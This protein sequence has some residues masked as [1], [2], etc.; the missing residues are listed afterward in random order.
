MKSFTNRGWASQAFEPA[1]S[2]YR[3]GS[4]CSTF[5]VS[6][7]SAVSRARLDVSAAIVSVMATRRRLHMPRSCSSPRRPSRDAFVCR[8]RRAAP[9]HL[10][11]LLLRAP[12]SS[13]S[14]L[15]TASTTSIIGATPSA[16]F[17]S[18]LSLPAESLR[19]GFVRQGSNCVPSAG[20]AALT[21]SAS[22][23][24]HSPGSLPTVATARALRRRISRSHRRNQ[25]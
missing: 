14:I 13:A 12:L 11:D 9:T 8:D 3:A 20:G 4:T 6:F 24:R 18:P 15:R 7:V 2:L 19:P 23:A 10:R 1:G 25:S 17:F 5:S 22:S 16:F 21:S